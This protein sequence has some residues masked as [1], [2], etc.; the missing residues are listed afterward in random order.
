[1]GSELRDSVADSLL[2]VEPHLVDLGVQTDVT[3]EGELDRLVLTRDGLRRGLDAR[4]THP[5]RK[6]LGTERRDRERSISLNTLC[7]AGIL[8]F[9][10]NSKISP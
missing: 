5:T 8:K 1:M 2:E 7:I 10:T 4:T 9:E 3:E 6:L